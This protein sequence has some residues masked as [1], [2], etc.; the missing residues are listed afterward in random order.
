M[1]TSQKSKDSLFDHKKLSNGTIFQPPVGAGPDVYVEA[2]WGIL[3]DL[4]PNILIPLNRFTSSED[5]QVSC[6]SQVCPMVH[7]PLDPSKIVA[8]LVSCFASRFLIKLKIVFR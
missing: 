1:Q 6:S 5:Q 3:L 2:L 4:K 7:T 8:G